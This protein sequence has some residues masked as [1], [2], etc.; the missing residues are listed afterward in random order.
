MLGKKLQ[1]QSAAFL[2]D[3]EMAK[4]AL[5]REERLKAE[6]KNQAAAFEARLAKIRSILGVT[7]IAEIK[8]EINTVAQMY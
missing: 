1:D 3:L 6:L 5:G 2:S 8:S 4:G 7:A